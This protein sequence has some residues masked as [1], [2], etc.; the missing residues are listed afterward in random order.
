[1]L[2]PEEYDKIMT[3]LSNNSITHLLQLWYAEEHGGST[4]VS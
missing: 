3:R 4:P 2:M 1:M